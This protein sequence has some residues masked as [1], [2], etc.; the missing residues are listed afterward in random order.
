M[1]L[2]VIVDVFFYEIRHSINSLNND[3]REIKFIYLF[4]YK[5]LFEVCHALYETK[6]N[7]NYLMK[8]FVCLC[9]VWM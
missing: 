2:F 7:L 3:E 8:V 1:F 9:V 6:E 5:W 4:I